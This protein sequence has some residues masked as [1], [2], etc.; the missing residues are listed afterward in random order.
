[1]NEHSSVKMTLQSIR[2]LEEY[3]DSSMRRSFLGE[4]LTESEIFGYI[5]G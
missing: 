3:L 1:M 4:I 5:T 2:E